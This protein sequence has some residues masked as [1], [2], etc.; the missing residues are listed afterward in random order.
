MQVIGLVNTVRKEPFY[1]RGGH[2]VSA[3]KDITVDGRP[4]L[5]ELEADA[6]QHFDVVSALTSEFPSGAVE[7][8]DDLL[9]DDDRWRVSMGWN[10]RPDEVPIY[11][12][13][14]DYDLLCGGIVATME[15]TGGLVRLHSFRYT[16]TDDGYNLR[17]TDSIKAFGFTFDAAQFDRVMTEARSGFAAEAAAWVRPDWQVSVIR[18]FVRRLRARRISS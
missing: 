12:C 16:S 10:L 9:G 4:L 8:L 3:F 11:F 14:I 18:R 2:P 6:R 13:P 5:P 1:N 17:V 7:F 15:R